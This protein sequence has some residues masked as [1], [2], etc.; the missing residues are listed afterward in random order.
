MK[1]NYLVIFQ[2]I[3]TTRIKQIEVH[4][5]SKSKDHSCTIIHDVDHVSTILVQLF[6]IPSN[7]KKQAHA[8]ENPF[9]RLA[10]GLQ[11]KRPNVGWA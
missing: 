4:I 10:L 5:F 6:H 11:A 2:S 9:G 3:K 8:G 1:N 7:L